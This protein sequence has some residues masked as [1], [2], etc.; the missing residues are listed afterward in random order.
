LAAAIGALRTMFAVGASTTNTTGAFM[1]I[2]T[3]LF[4]VEASFDCAYLYLRIGR[5]EWFGGPGAV[6]HS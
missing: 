5:W 1:L 6:R 4:E 2:K 3:R